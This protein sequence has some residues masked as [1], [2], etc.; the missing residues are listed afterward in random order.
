MSYYYSS[1]PGPRSAYQR[2][3]QQ[4]KYQLLETIPT[5]NI[6]KNGLKMQPKVVKYTEAS[7]LA[8]DENDEIRDCDFE[9]AE[10]SGLVR[11]IG[12]GGKE[13]QVDFVT[14][15]MQLNP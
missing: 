14:H 9:G 7:A 4:R 11:I 5:K 15:N 12:G 1:S 6:V 13:P 8:M 10:M 2:Q 3:H